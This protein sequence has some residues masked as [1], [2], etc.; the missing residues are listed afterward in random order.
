MLKQFIATSFL[1]VFLFSFL[2]CK[3]LKQSSSKDKTERS[4]ESFQI[5]DLKIGSGNN[6][7]EIEKTEFKIGEII[8]LN[9]SAKNLIAVKEKNVK[10]YWVREDLTVRDSRNAIVLLKA[11][12]IDQKDLISRKPLEFVNEIS[13]KNIEGLKTGNY[14][15]ALLVTD[16]IGFKTD[17]QA[18][19]I[20]L[21]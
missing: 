15:I 3:N 16:M 6:K 19:E 11:G 13:L 1:F 5:T 2:S 8:R 4:K 18:L 12:I 20:K 17:T 7:I 10:Y 21:K 14:T 9:F